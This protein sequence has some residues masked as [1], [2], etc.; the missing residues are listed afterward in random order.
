MHFHVLCPELLLCCLASGQCF[1][2]ML[3]D[4]IL[5]SYQVLAVVSLSTMTHLSFGFLFDVVFMH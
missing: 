3:E 1:P 2:L 5:A 4:C